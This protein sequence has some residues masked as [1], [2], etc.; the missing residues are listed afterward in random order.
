MKQLFLS[1]ILIG[2]LAATA[3]TKTPPA[4][5]AA[6][7]QAAPALKTIIDSV[8]YAAGVSVA[9]FYKQQGIT[10]LNSALVVKAINDVTGNKTALLSDEACQEV[11][12]RYISGAQQS[13]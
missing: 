13:K 6:K 12:M 4:K 8:S 2:S 7:P 11:M 1:F 9:N 10:K 5:T 3:Q